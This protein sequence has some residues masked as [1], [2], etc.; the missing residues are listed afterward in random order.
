MLRTPLY[1]PLLTSFLFANS[2]QE[3]YAK[4]KDK[5][6]KG[7]IERIKLTQSK[8]IKY[9]DYLQES[10]Y[11]AA[12]IFLHPIYRMKHLNLH[13]SIENSTK[14]IGLVREK[15]I[16]HRE[17]QKKLEQDLQRRYDQERPQ[18]NKDEKEPRQF[19]QILSLF[20]TEVLDEDDEFDV[21]LKQPALR[22]L[23]RTNKDTK[24][25]EEEAFLFDVAKFWSDES[26]RSIFPYLSSFALEVY[27]TPAMSD[28]PEHLFSN[29]KRTMDWSRMSLGSDTLE[30]TECIK[31]WVSFRKN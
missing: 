2:S 9:F 29:G 10:P 26:Q 25:K 16:V 15:W 6:S 11:Y 14:A 12:A 3:K 13:W 1:E 18:G 4:Q 23:D 21:W 8:L 22:L 31:S 20:T 24:K 7:F 28:G 30:C 5:D 27:S 17:T 19:N